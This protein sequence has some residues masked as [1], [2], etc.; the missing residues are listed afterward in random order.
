MQENQQKNKE[1]QWQKHKENH[2]KNKGNQWKTRKNKENSGKP[3]KMK[4]TPL[5]IE[6]QKKIPQTQIIIPQTIF[7]PYNIYL[8]A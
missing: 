3:R 6:I 4:G 8:S 2:V 5:Q 1:H 7:Y